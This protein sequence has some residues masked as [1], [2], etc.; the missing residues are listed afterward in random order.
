MKT[1]INYA[2]IVRT[3]GNVKAEERTFEGACE[4]LSCM[5]NTAMQLKQDFIH[6]STIWWVKNCT[7]EAKTLLGKEVRKAKDGGYPVFYLL[8]YCIAVEKA[9]EKKGLEIKSAYTSY[10]KSKK[11]F[12]FSTVTVEEL[13][14]VAAKEKAAIKR[15][16][17]ANK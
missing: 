15:I 1:K 10:R 13:T 3:Y 12:D 5:A 6:H 2:E 16:K 7:A 11:N 9:L 14:K 17:E 4:R 8:Q